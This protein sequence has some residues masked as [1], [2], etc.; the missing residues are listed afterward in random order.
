[1]ASE[2]GHIEVVKLLLNHP[3]VDPS[4]KNNYGNNFIDL[5]N[6]SLAIRLASQ[7]GYNE[8]VKLLL[9]HPKVDPSAENNSGMKFI[10]FIIYF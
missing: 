5:V 4:S 8:V 10:D 2:N 3:K 6:V 9:N 1:L 7:R